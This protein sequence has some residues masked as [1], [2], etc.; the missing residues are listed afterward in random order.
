MLSRTKT[1]NLRRK[2]K[3]A[4][5][6]EGCFHLQEK[7]GERVSREVDRPRAPIVFPPSSQGTPRGES[8]PLASVV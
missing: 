5:S 7:A 8:A 4:R 6:G 1:E 3:G 2:E